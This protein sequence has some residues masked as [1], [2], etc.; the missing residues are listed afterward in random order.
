MS[1]PMCKTDTTE[2]LGHFMLECPLLSNN[3]RQMF[4]VFSMYTMK[5]TMLLI[6]GHFSQVPNVSFYSA[7]LAII[8]IYDFGYFT[9]V[10]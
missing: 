3:R 5:S 8:L 6:S 1:S 7:T 4:N 9:T 2:G 10:L